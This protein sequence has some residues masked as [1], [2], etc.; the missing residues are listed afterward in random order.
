M[1]D[2][3]TTLATGLFIANYSTTQY[4]W[5]EI[6]NGVIINQG[7]GNKSGLATTEG[8][9]TTSPGTTGGG[10]TTN[11][12]TTQPATTE[13]PSTTEEALQNYEYY[14][15]SSSSALAAWESGSGG[16]IYLN[17]VTSRFY[18]LQD[19]SQ[20]ADD[21]YYITEWADTFAGCGWMRLASG[22]IVETN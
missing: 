14:G 16:D 9:T 4:I 6:V 17:T 12:P 18:K 1:D 3:M 5:Y 20:L 22:Y 21:G 15:Y 11:S 8:P 19:G 7:E 2:E 10:M 13:S